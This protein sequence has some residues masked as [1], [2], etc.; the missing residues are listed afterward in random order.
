MTTTLQGSN[1]EYNYTDD[2]G[3][4]LHVITGTQ[5]AILSIEYEPAPFDPIVEVA[6]RDIPALIATLAAILANANTQVAA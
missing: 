6:Y 4:L 3:D 2:R 5:G 1:V